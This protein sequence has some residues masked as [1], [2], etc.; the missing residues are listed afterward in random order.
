MDRRSGT[1]VVGGEH[2]DGNPGS[3][4]NN[5][6]PD[7]RVGW[8]PG[9]TRDD[10]WTTGPGRSTE[11]GSIVWSGFVTPT[12]RTPRPHPRSEGPVVHRPLVRSGPRTCKRWVTPGHLPVLP[13]P[14]PSR[15]LSPFPVTSQSSLVPTQ[16]TTQPPQSVFQSLPNRPLSPSPVTFQ[17]SPVPT[18]SLLRTPQWVSQSSPVDHPV[19]PNPPQ[20]SLSRHPT[21]TPVPGDPGADLRR[22]TWSPA[23]DPQCRSVVRLDHT[24]RLPVE[25][26]AHTVPPPMESGEWCPGRRRWDCEGKRVLE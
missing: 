26:L 22:V 7:T 19:P 12:T 5:G 1:W 6:S 16:S 8:V 21:T 24:T 17:S 11:D 2:L 18:Q 9:L 15:P 13:S 23:C 14:S 10:Q 4:G 3:G 20:W 25:V